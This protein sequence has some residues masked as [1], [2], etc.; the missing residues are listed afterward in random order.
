[1]IDLPDFG[2]AWDYENG[3]YLTCGVD[4]M[5]KLLAHYELFR[6]SMELPGDIV[7]CGVYKGASLARWAMFRDLFN[8]SHARRMVAFDTYE[9]FADTD[10]EADR[11]F[12][13]TYQKDAPCISTEQMSK[14]L[15]H[16]ECN[17]QVE[18]VAGDI[19]ETVP[20]Y[21]TENPAMRISLLNLDTDYYEPALTVLE[22]LY[23]LVV[24]GGV[25]ILDNYGVFA[26]ETQAVDEYF[27]GQVQIR[28]FSF[29]PTPCYLIRE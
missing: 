19:V 24:P 26:G 18:L 13:D 10:F 12:R 3:F 7:E 20:W 9:E 11:E 29:A 16:K 22:Y 23:P 8:G 17:R 1:M 6:M 25:V 14:V 4:R 21:V 28:R 5:S 27:Q 2:R 15:A